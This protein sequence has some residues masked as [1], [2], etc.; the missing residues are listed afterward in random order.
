MRQ[1]PT[2]YRLCT[3]TFAT[4]WDL[5]FMWQCDYTYF[6]ITNWK[7]ALVY[8]TLCMYIRHSPQLT[9]L[10]YVNIQSALMRRTHLSLWTSFKF[11][12]NQLIWGAQSIERDIWKT[13]SYFYN[14]FWFSNLQMCI[15]K[16]T[17]EPGKCVAERI[18][19]FYIDDPKTEQGSGSWNLWLTNEWEIGTQRFAAI[20]NCIE[21]V[22]QSFH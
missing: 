16:H 7:R 4:K 6:A 17:N 5:G 20:V 10:G 8:R 13:K 19:V 15:F 22:E 18:Q 11:V 14:G 9:T 3:R 2:A 21:G 12:K 1:V